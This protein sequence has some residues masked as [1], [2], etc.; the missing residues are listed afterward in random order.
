MKQSGK[1]VI[2]GIACLAVVLAV[3]YLNSTNQKNTLETEIIESAKDFSFEDKIKAIKTDNPNANQIL[4]DCGIDEHCVVEALWDLASN[5]Q[6]KTVLEALNAVSTAYDKTGYYCHGPAH[7]LGMFLYGLTGNL[8]KTLE[9]SEKRDCG[10]AMYHGAIENYF[11]TEMVLND[12]Q[13]EEIEFVDICKSLADDAK[14]MIR[15]E[16]VHG[17]GHGLAKVYGYD[18]FSSVKR[19]DEFPEAVERRVCYEGIFM[20]NVVAHQL[21]NGGSFDENDI[22]FPCNRLD[23][24]YSGACYFYHVTYILEQTKKIDK[25]FEKCNKVTPETSLIFCYMGLGRQVGPSFFD[26][27]EELIPICKVGLVEYQRFCYQGALFVIVDQRGFDDSFKACKAFPESFKVDCYTLLGGWIRIET[28]TTDEI[29]KA[30]S[31][32]ENSKY[33]DICVNAKI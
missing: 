19:C 9:F 15:I 25:T 17:I 3:F 11:L 6:E 7:H 24:K 18:V 22:F 1:F 33:L 2:I 32:A 23:A 27:P 28:P 8:T 5:E 13:V 20:E 12:A 16:C 29:E 31:K 10:G 21:V 4:S 14:K 26:N 30:C